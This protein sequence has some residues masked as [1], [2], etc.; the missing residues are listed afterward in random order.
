MEG[1]GEEGGGLVEGWGRGK[2]MEGDR[3]WSRKG[4]CGEVRRGGGIEGNGCG[5]G[6]WLSDVGKG[7]GKM[8]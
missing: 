2:R 1:W 8:G 3:G 5:D 4:E 6:G 7:G